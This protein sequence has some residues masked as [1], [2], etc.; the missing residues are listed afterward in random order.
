MMSL[1]EDDSSDEDGVGGPELVGEQEER[2]DEAAIGSD[3]GD[4]ENIMMAPPDKEALRTIRAIAACLQGG[5]EEN[6]AV[7]TAREKIAKSSSVATL[8]AV[9]DLV[10]VDPATVDKE[11]K[12]I[13]LPLV[14]ALIQKVR[15]LLNC[16]CVMIDYYQGA[17]RAP[18]I[19]CTHRI[20]PFRY[21]AIT[22]P[23]T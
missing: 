19:A 10:G 11:G 4:T 14:K 20:S 6:D 23:R 18:N 3:D 8:K 22:C 17:F 21:Q 7:R 9:C 12:N 16:T 1:W 2:R 5:L 13:R 15:E